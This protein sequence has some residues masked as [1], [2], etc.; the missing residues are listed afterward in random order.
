MIRGL[1]GAG[2]GKTGN[3]RNMIQ[4]A[5]EYNFGAVDTNGKALREL[6]G[7]Q[8]A[9]AANEFLQEQGVRIG[10]I[11]LSA[12]WRIDDVQFRNG[13][14]QLIEDAKAASQVGCKV[15]TTF[16]LPSTDLE[17]AQ[18]MAAATRRLRLAAQIMD[19]YG[20]RLALEFVGP[21]HLRTKW[22]N[23]FIWTVDQTRYTNEL[24]TSDIKKLDKSQIVHV[25]IN[26]APSVPVAEALDNNRLYPGEGVIDLAGFL[27]ALK[28]IGYDGVVAQEVLTP[29][30]P[31]E[32]SEALVR[33]SQAAFDRVFAAAGI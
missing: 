4:L 22:K 33:K 30:P 20:I 11:G 10:A 26:D 32:S 8:E 13:L 23:P 14:A 7:D 21:H 27:Q 15:C 6:I 28:Q 29:Q 9:S 16:I 12:Q 3:L 18:F 17:A 5:A 2:I 19:A 31:T 25:H 24:G 1:T